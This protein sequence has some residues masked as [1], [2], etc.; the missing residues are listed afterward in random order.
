MMRSHTHTWEDMDMVNSDSQ[1]PQK[2]SIKGFQFLTSLQ[3]LRLR[4]CPKLASIP[5]EGLLF[6]FHNFISGCPKIFWVTSSGLIFGRY[7][8]KISRIPCMGTMK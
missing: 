3:S 7:W 2:L 5:V 8:P 6:H 1:S 4:N